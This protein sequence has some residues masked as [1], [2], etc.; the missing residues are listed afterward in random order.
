[1]KRVAR[2]ALAV[3][4]WLFACAAGAH[5]F[6]DHAEPAVGSTVHATPA[7]VRI[8]FSERLEPAFST[9]ELQDASGRRVGTQDATV[10]ASDPA[11]LRMAVPP[12]A[13]G[14]YRVKWHVLSVDTHVTEGDF[15]FTVA[16]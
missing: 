5:A 4:A 3:A 14:R 8:W 11:L 10:D 7:E 2:V 15:T 13:P 9:A 6:L 16:P 1:M 12:L